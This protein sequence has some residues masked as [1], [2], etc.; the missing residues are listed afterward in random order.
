MLSTIFKV[1]TVV[2]GRVHRA[3][4][5]FGRRTAA[6]D[7]RTPHR[8]HQGRCIFCQLFLLHA[9][10][11]WSYASF[12][13]L[14]YKLFSSAVRFRFGCPMRP[15]SVCEFFTQIIVALTCTGRANLCVCHLSSVVAFGGEV[16]GEYAQAGRIVIGMT[17]VSAALSGS[18]AMVCT[19]KSEAP[20]GSCGRV[21]GKQTGCRN[22]VATEWPLSLR[23]TRVV[24]DVA[25]DGRHAGRNLKQKAESEHRAT[26]Y[27]IFAT[28]NLFLLLLPFPAHLFI[29]NLYNR[30]KTGIVSNG[31]SNSTV[32]PPS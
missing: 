26:A 28:R 25:G 15:T 6:H 22:C 16:A 3:V 2:P 12:N 14:E 31:V 32:F 21:R 1:A 19:S 13:N 10:Y 24:D 23:L 4:A 8:I 27:V 20:E 5:L 30:V 18:N 17:D 11:G 7:R 9:I 29:D